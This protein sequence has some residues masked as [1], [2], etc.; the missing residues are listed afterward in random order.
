M[1][2]DLPDQV[3]HALLDGVDQGTARA[4]TLGASAAAGKLWKRVGNQFRRRQASL[5]P[6]ERAVLLAQPGQPVDAQALRRLLQRL[7]RQELQEFL[8]LYET[9]IHQN[10]VQGDWIAPGGIKYEAAGDQVINGSVKNV[11]NFSTGPG[12]SQQP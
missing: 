8:T 2:V 3:L 10:R 12:P 5:D 4:V 11:I 6:D 7:P 1:S 9:H